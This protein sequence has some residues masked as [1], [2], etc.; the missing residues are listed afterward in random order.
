MFKKVLLLNLSLASLGFQ[1]IQSSSS[2]QNGVSEL[3][4]DQQRPQQQPRPQQRD[5]LLT[6][7]NDGEADRISR[8]MRIVAA[9]AAVGAVASVAGVVA[10]V[11]LART[12]LK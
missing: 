1:D 12:F 9:T 4:R 7:Y 6:D 3:A 5:D 10:L 11:R 8:G 2:K